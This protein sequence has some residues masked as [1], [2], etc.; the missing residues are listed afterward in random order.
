MAH[1]MITVVIPYSPRSPGILRKALDSM[2]AQRDG[3]LF[4][5][6]IV[7]DDASPYPLVGPP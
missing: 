6:V 5:H 4:V 1:S 3:A 7:V 2:A